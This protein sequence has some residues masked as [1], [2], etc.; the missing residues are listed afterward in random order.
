MPTLQQTDSM[1]V[2]FGVLRLLVIRTTR[3]LYLDPK[4][5]R[6]M[7]AVKHRQAAVGRARD[8]ERILRFRDWSGIFPETSGT[9]ASRQLRRTEGEDL[10]RTL[11][12][13]RRTC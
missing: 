3:H 6:F 11:L 12:T 2:E 7:H 10:G 5:V 1:K 4:L 9:F 8:D 13:D